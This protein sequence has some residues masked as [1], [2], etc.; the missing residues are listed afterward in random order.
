M[1]NI[2]K[3]AENTAKK[4]ITSKA[5]SKELKKIFETTTDDYFLYSL[6]GSCETIEEMEKIRKES[7]TD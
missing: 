2:D 7:L 6:F 1:L 4:V 3:W 5:A